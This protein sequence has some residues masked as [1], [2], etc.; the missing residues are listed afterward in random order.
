MS[1]S[2]VTKAM[3]FPCSCRL[4]NR[5]MISYDVREMLYVVKIY[6]IIIYK[7]VNKIF[8]MHIICV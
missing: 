3:V 1:D 4:W 5:L 2:C 6:P 8:D 7:M